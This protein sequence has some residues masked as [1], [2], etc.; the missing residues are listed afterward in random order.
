M[1]NR[2]AVRDGWF[3]LLR[4]ALASA[5]PFTAKPT[6]DGRSGQP[7]MDAG[8]GCSVPCVWMA[9]IAC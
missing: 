3:A 2:E 8:T 1:T 6:L 4:D 7:I 9:A 5:D